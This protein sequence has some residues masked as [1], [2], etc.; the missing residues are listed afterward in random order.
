VDKLLSAALF[1]ITVSPV[2]FSF[3]SL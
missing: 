3:D 1:V 2:D